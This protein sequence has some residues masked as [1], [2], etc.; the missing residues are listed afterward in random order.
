MSARFTI[1]RC[2]LAG[3]LGCGLAVAA[4]AGQ[5]A[6]DTFKFTD[7]AQYFT[8]P[9]GVD[10]VAITATGGGGGAGEAEMLNSTT[11][12]TLGGS[13]GPGAVVKGFVP[14]AAGDVLEVFVGG[15]GVAGGGDPLTAGGGGAGGLSSGA[16]LDGGAGGG[17]STNIGGGGGGGATEIIDTTTKMV[18]LA[19]G[20]GGGGGGYGAGASSY[21]GGNGGS[22]GSAN[23]GG[24]NGQGTNAIGYMGAYGGPGGQAAA[25]AQGGGGDGQGYG[26][27]SSAGSGGGGGGGLFQ[28]AVGANGGGGAGGSAGG[29]STGNASA[30]GGGGGAGASYTAPS[31]Q[32]TT[33]TTDKT[34]E[35]GSAAI[36][37]SG[38]PVNVNVLAS[39]NPGFVGSNVTLTANV[40]SLYGGVQVQPVGAVDFSLPNPGDGAA[41]ED[42]GTVELPSS[43][44]ATLTVPVSEI[45]S[46]ANQYTIQA[47]YNAVGP[48]FANAQ[49]TATLN[50]HT[51]VLSTTSLT[52]SANPATA[53]QPV[54][55]T[56]QV[57]PPTGNPTATGTI[58]FSQTSLTTGA[59]IVLGTVSLNSSGAASY[60]TSALAAGANSVYAAYNGD[61]N[62]APQTSPYVTEQIQPA[63]S[64]TT[65]K[66]NPSP[67]TVGHTYTVTANVAS[68]TG[69]PP[70]GTITFYSEGN[71]ISTA[72]LNGASPGLATI[73][74]AAPTA[75]GP[76][77]WQAVYNGDS[78][79][80]SSQ[81][82][83]VDETANA[84]TTTLKFNPNLVTVG[85]TYTV[86]ATVT[87]PGLPAPTGTVTFYSEG[88]QISTATL[89][90]ASP[91]L[92]TITAAPPTA[93][94]PVTWQAV[95]NGGSD[96]TS[97]S[98]VVNQT[99]LAAG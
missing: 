44:T 29:G 68:A 62:Y 34:A 92:A 15:Q 48:E 14:V 82:P 72:T 83:V 52:A 97:Q 75:P 61:G 4:P 9:S 53:G 57:H 47:S 94:G 11:F 33:I 19:A 98:T 27:F 59:N 50:I 24:A 65:L 5:A 70:T 91:G 6:A 22:A 93:P 71:Q 56:A 67:A 38:L 76:V 95:Y 51:R 43:G 55:F 32:N 13:G 63:P 16:V 60:T 87:A 35:N 21:V 8:V 18:L 7:V 12:G 49:G 73:T 40:Q 84:T 17:G 99:A 96:S 1:R 54:T 81:S 10:A 69:R 79:N 86:T 3:A 64:T 80:K 77:T 36:L 39:P 90:G 85:H 28:P 46:G 66:F 74:A 30:G 37:T 20:A 58:D 41:H 42:L 31:A 26:A 23:A 89:N 25:G 78:S 45:S 2:L 88:N